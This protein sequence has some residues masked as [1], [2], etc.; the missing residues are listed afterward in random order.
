MGK[1]VNPNFPGT[2]QSHDFGVWGGGSCS[3]AASAAHYVRYSLTLLASTGTVRYTC[4]VVRCMQQ[5]AT[6]P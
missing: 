2:P 1:D 3:L 5:G 6:V 4:Y